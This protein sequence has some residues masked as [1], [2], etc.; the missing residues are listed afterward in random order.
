MAN[1]VHV[2]RPVISFILSIPSILIS[3]LIFREHVLP[4]PRL[5]HCT[6]MCPGRHVQVYGSL[7]DM[8]IS[9]LSYFWKTS[10]IR[11]RRRTGAT[12]YALPREEVSAANQYRGDDFEA[13]ARFE[14]RRQRREGGVEDAVAGGGRRGRAAPCQSTPRLSFT[15]STKT[16][17]MY[18]SAM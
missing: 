18:F 4:E 11:E 15:G 1:G 2:T 10:K 17:G 16:G 7:V 13:A 8:D 14:R 3:I 12:Y 9:Q 6:D 5:T